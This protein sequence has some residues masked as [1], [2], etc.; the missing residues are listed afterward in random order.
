LWRAGQSLPFLIT[1]E[2][3]RELGVSGGHVA[4]PVQLG[5]NGE[6]GERYAAQLARGRNSFG[7]G[8][9]GRIIAGM[10]G[11]RPRFR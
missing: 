11:W 8:P 7:G 5:P 3:Y 9:S 6:I 10:P 1:P 2:Q 4:N